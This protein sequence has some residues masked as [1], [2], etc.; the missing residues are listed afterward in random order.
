MPKDKVRFTKGEPGIF[1]SS[2]G[3]RRGFCRTCGSPLSYEGPVHPGFM[4]LYAASL[5]A[6]VIIEPE[7]HVYSDEQL[8]WFEVHDQLPRYGGSISAEKPPLR[9]GPRK[10]R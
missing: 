5:E 1:K 3:V 4:D 9:K 2:S 10:S 7:F 8:P 6:D